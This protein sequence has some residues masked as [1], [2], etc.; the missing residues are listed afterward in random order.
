MFFR[1]SQKRELRLHY[2]P[3]RGRG[4]GRG[5]IGRGNKVDGGFS[6]L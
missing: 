1:I 6:L 4:E 2:Y 3:D 5:E